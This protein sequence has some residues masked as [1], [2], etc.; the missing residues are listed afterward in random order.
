MARGHRRV[1]RV[2]QQET[3]GAKGRLGHVGR[4]AGQADQRRLLIAAHVPD[5]NDPVEPIDIGLTQIATA[6]HSSS[7][8]RP[9]NRRVTPSK[10]RIV[11]DPTV[12]VPLLLQDARQGAGGDR[13]P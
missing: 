12:R 10:I 8:A 4:K 7:T 9:R 1:A 11:A 3:A 2:D 5:R 13:G 6:P